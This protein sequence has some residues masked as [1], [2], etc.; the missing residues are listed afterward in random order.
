MQRKNLFVIEAIYPTFNFKNVKVLINGLK[1]QF[2]SFAKIF[3]S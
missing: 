1:F 2:K 3:H